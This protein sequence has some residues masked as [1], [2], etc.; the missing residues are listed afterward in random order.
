MQTI[1]TKIKEQ[2]GFGKGVGLNFRGQNAFQTTVGGFISIG[3]WVFFF[4]I[5]MSGVNDWYNK[6]NPEI[7][8]Y[9]VV[10]LIGASEETNLLE[11]RGGF[12]IGIQNETG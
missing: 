10:D 7:V 11:Y 9:D 5:F 8:T 2:D 1:L 3:I 12:I 6:T 4:F